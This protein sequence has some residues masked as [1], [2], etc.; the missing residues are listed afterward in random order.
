MW[1]N[2]EH[3]R[4]TRKRQQV[5]ANPPAPAMSII[6]IM[7]IIIFEYVGGNH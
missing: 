3:H 6:F 4:P 1:N 7:E 5:P 2:V